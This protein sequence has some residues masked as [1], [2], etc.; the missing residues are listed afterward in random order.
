MTTTKKY[1][2]AKADRASPVTTRGTNTGTTQGGR[3]HMITLSN[4]HSAW[5]HGG[6]VTALLAGMAALAVST[7]GFASAAGAA[8]TTPSLVKPSGIEAA[9]SS[10]YL[11]GYQATPTGGLA[12]ASVTFTVPTVSCT[13]TDIADGAFVQTGV[14]TDT[15]RTYALIEA[16]CTQSSPKYYYLL[17]T[18]SG[19]VQQPAAA[20]DVV[21]A[22]LFQ[23]GTSTWAEIHD[24]TNGQYWLDDN[25]VNQGDTVVDIGTY[26]ED[27]VDFPVP[28]FSKIKFTNA[29]VNGDYLAFDS[30][31]EYNTLNGG[32]LLIKAGALTTSATGSSFSDTFK[33]AF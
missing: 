5:R 16:V 11:A 9:S 26:S 17:G 22:S 27:F 18:R 3:L 21:V 14:Y 6:R 25:S 24:L 10:V 13:P 32:D 19:G 2:D 4:M 7:L 31:T 8:G 15:S 29:T 12:S 30:P 28:T 1:E 20:G 33:H 23:S